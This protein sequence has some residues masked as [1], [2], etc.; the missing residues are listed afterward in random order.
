MKKISKNLLYISICIMFIMQIFAIFNFT[1]TP[2]K[3]V[4]SASDIQVQN[5]D[6]ENHSVFIHT[7][8]HIAIIDQKVYFVDSYDECIKA[9]DTK[10]EKF[11]SN[12]LT[13]SGYTVIDSAFSGKNMFLLVTHEMQTKILVVNLEKI[14]ENGTSPAAIITLATNINDYDKINVEFFDGGSSNYLIALTPKTSS[15]ANSMVILIDSTFNVAKEVNISTVGGATNEKIVKFLILKSTETEYYF[16]FGYKNELYY[17]PCT[18]S[19]IAGSSGSQSTTLRKFPTDAIQKDSST[20]IFDINF[21]TVI[22]DETS[23]KVETAFV[24]TFYNPDETRY[25]SSVYGYNINNSDGTQTKFTLITS[26]SVIQSDTVISSSNEYFIYPD[27]QTINYLSITKNSTGTYTKKLKTSIKNPEVVAE[28]YTDNNYQYMTANKN[29][30]V[31]PSPWADEP[32]HAVSKNEDVAVIGFGKIKD[33]SDEISDFYFCLFTSGDTNYL[34]YVKKQDLTQKQVYENPN[35]TNFPVF[36]VVSNTRLYSLPTIASKIETEDTAYYA[37]FIPTSS[38]IK[39]NSKITLVDT[40]CKYTV[41][42][43][44]F[45]RVKVNG[46][47]VGYI[48]ADNV[49]FSSDSRNFVVTN[50]SIKSDN[51][52]VY[53]EDGTIIDI[54][55]K[56]FRVRINGVRNTKTGKTSITYNDEYGNEFTGYIS[57]D[58]VKANSWSSLQ[59]LGSVLIAI[60][61]GLL[62][63]ILIFAKRKVGA[64]GEKYKKSQ[65]ANYKENS[66]E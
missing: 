52:V 60:N 2:I 63:L 50:A 43:R 26:L 54:L 27:S 62:I 23:A 33:T 24:L 47:D 58:S 25:S 48:D 57:T 7:P 65:K 20:M 56:D 8:T 38:I 37:H 32:L 14:L 22:D 12:T 31:L 19:S 49:L 39:D 18:I 42:G 53:R 10:T 46:T 30:L 28:Y 35:Y 41:N 44:A 21:I 34:G 6:I 59:I 5:L 55:N 16:I 13:L 66:I 29:T 4:A 40:I 3:G 45:V 9:Y 1:N 15:S 11:Y 36:K 61:I 17:S 51:T 64:H